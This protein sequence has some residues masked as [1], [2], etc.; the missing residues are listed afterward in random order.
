MDFSA[1]ENI[2]D[3]LCTYDSKFDPDSIH[4][5]KIKLKL[6]AEL[7]KKEY[8]SL[9]STAKKAYTVLGCRDYARIDIRLRNGVFY[10]LDINA[11]P[12]I[13]RE[14]SMAAA[15]ELAGYSYNAMIGNILN[16]AIKR[17]LSLKSSVKK[18][19]K[20]RVK[21]GSLYECDLLNFE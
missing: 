19:S 9:R 21:K 3:R 11:N 14:T 16:L 12:D 17:H 2:H 10:V 6:P 20:I 18:K 8:N 1:F 7:S 4:Y 15:A 5:K 13:S